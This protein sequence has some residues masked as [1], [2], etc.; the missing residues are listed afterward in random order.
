MQTDVLVDNQNRNITG[1]L[2][3]LTT[4]SQVE[5]FGEGNYIALSLN[6][7]DNHFEDY[8]SV[9]IGVLDT[10][11]TGSLIEIIDAE[12]KYGVFKVTDTTAESFIVRATTADAVME[13][14]YSLADLVLTG[15]PEPP[16]PPEPIDYDEAGQW[17]FGASGVPEDYE[18]QAGQWEFRS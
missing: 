7:P 14:V 17:N 11:Q 13:Q 8:T 3:Y 5:E 10:M 16:E 12:N 15:P 18:P 9:L 4:G 2:S 6:S 1:T